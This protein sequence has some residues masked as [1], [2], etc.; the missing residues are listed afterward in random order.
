MSSGADRAGDFTLPA[1]PRTVDTA[2][3]RRGSKL[4]LVFYTEDSTPLCTRELQPFVADYASIRELGAEVVAISSDDLD[5]HRRFAER[6]D[7]PFPLASDADLVV[8][9]AYGVADT[10][11][12]RS[13]RAVFVVAEDGTILHANRRY[14]PSNPSEYEAAV[15]ALM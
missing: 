3:L 12:R 10:E 7:I 1:V 11:Q 9:K 2:V 6:L 5:S 15:A 13:R 14:T 4:L 8:S